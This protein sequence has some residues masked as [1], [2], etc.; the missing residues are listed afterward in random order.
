LRRVVHARLEDDRYDAFII[1]ADARDDKRVEFALTITSGTHK[2]EVVE[3]V[4]ERFV[5]R[6][7]IDLV[8]LPCTLVVR[9]GVPRIEP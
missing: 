7:P 2:G 8:G 4:A 9:D 1:W 3:I 5:T 6:E